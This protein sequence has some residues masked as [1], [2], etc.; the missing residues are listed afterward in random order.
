MPHYNSGFWEAN[1]MTVSNSGRKLD[2]FPVFCRFTGAWKRTS[3][4][5][6]AF[7]GLFLAT[8]LPSAASAGLYLGVKAGV[9][10]VEIEDITVD[11]SPTNA[12]LLLGYRFPSILSGLSA[13]FEMTGSVR[14]GEV[15]DTDLGVTSRG[16][17]AAYRTSGTFYLKARIGLMQAKLTGDFE[18]SENG[19]TYGL[20][21]GFKPPIIRLELELDH[22]LIDDDV[23]YTSLA[24]IYA[25]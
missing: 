13:E 20:A 19:E 25:L 3:I 2:S 4:W 8:L 14:D 24:L 10:D 11:T 15:L 7:V 5:P 17:Y 22:T 21:V 12:G 1:T 6:L 23:G 9:T 16:I 18:E